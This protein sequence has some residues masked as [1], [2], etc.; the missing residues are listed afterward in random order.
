MDR[1]NITQSVLHCI[2]NNYPRKI[3]EELES[4]INTEGQSIAQDTNL[5]YSKLKEIRDRHRI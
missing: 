3:V 5:L 1:Q 4:L 2:K